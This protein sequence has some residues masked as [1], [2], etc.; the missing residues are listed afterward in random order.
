[1]RTGSDTMPYCL[2]MQSSEGGGDF[3]L[4]DAETGKDFEIGCDETR[5]DLAMRLGLDIDGIP[6]D[7]RGVVT[8]DFLESHVGRAFY[9]DD[10]AFGRRA[11]A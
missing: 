9:L 8:T 5:T 6:D 11:F 1:M 2:Y 3:L 4:E 7:F 10:Y